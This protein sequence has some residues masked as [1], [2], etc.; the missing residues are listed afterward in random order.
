MK[1]PSLVSEV[2]VSSNHWTKGA[3]ARS[4]H[5][6]A[7]ADVFDPK[8]EQFSLGGAINKV[9]GRSHIKALPSLIKTQVREYLQEHFEHYLSIEEW[10][11]HPD[12][13]FEDIQQVIQ[14]LD[15]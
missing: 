10:N 9:Y 13:T 3:F 8:A 2:L 4:S 15:L 7:P 1:K 12:R 5:P 6:K 14:A 11:D